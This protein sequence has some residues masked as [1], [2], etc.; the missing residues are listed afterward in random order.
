MTNG[1][2]FLPGPPNTVI[3]IEWDTPMDE[4]VL[5]PN[6]VWGI[7]I[8]GIPVAITAQEWI[9]PND[10]RLTYVGDTPDVSGLA[11]LLT[12]DP[13]LRSLSGVIAKAPQ[14]VSF[15]P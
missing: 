12:V 14:S 5:P 11:T 6:G 3:S 2:V 9:D 4:T 15:F 7:D 13:N 10:L 1:S 8:N